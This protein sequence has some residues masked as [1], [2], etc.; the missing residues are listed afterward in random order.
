MF[1]GDTLSPYN[2][3]YRAMLGNLSFTFDS[4]VKCKAVENID[5]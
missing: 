5:Q 1:F 2:M 3:S 4:P